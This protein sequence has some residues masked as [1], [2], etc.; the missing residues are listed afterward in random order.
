M[1]TLPQHALHRTVVVVDVSAFSQRHRTPQE[2]IRRGL[3]TALES[4]FEDCGLDWSATHHEDRGDGVFV[5]VPPD[6]PKS[7]VVSGLP[8]AL[9]G[10]LRRYNATRNED[11]RIRLRMAI[12]AGEVQHDEHGV[13]GDDVT[14]AFRLL[15]AKPLRDALAHSTALF[16]LIV[17]QRFFEDVIRPDPAADPDSFRRVDVDVKEVHGHAW[18]HVPNGGAPVLNRRPTRHRKKRAKPRRA[19]ALLMLPLLFVGITNGAGAAPPAVPPCPPPVQLNVLVSAEKEEVVRSLALELEDDSGRHNPLGCKEFNALVFTGKSAK[20]AAEALGRGWQPSD[21]TEVGAEPHVWLPDTTAEVRAVKTALLERTDVRLHLRQGVAL[22]P[23]VLGASEEL[24]AQIA[25][26]DGEVEWRDVTRPAAVDTSSG[27]GLAAA[28]ALVHA[29]LG[30]LDLSR[31]DVARKLHDI[32]RSTTTDE[33]CVGGV[34]LIGSEKAVADTEGCRVLYPRAGALVL[35]HPFVEVERP[36]RPNQRRLRIVHRFLE[37]LVSAR[38]QEQFRRAGFRDVAGNIGA[39]PGPGVR[40]DQ[41][42]RLS[43]EPDARAVREAWEAASRRRVIG[44]ARDG[45]PAANVFANLVWGLA[46][47]RD[48]VIDL[49][50]TE[51][52]AEAG[53]EQGANVVV[54]V[55]AAQVPPIAKAVSGPV[56][57]VAVGITEGA[58]AASTPLY[59]AAQ[60]HGGQCHEIVARNGSGPTQ[61]QEDALDAVARAAWGG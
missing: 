14:L 36:D 17:S 56:R 10:E 8:H 12:T 34:S 44:V 15:D 49:P 22:S 29:E 58:C 46:G 60:A 21:L 3:Y 24:A 61:R 2:E 20:A 32:T 55:S 1:G 26:Q 54:L 50:L 43:V 35:D 47:P 59:E 52:V 5:L 19:L 51:G 41:P 7:R 42:R 25:P 28:T 27:V 48:Q 6:V 4:A 45:S 37:H 18:L 38:A 39:R 9:L 31:R 16:A 57:V 53:V 30:G 40:L 13:V 33:P 23:V 11:A